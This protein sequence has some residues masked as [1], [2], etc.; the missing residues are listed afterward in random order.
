MTS[1]KRVLLLHAYSAHNAGDGLLV[2]ESIKLVREALGASTEF[3]IAASDPVSFS[4][5]GCL[6][7]NSK[8]SLR[9][10]S[11]A[12]RTTLAGI[13]DFDLVVGVGGGYQ[14]AGKVREALKMGLVH[15]PQ[16]V[17]S[18]RRSAGV[19]Y[20]P[21]SIGPLRLG[22]RRPMTRLLSK[23]EYV[24][25][26]DDRSL[27]EIGR[28]RPLRVPDLALVSGAWVD[29]SADPLNPVPVV[30]IRAI[31]GRV[32]AGVRELCSGLS[33]FDGYVQSATGGNDDRVPMRSVNPRSIVEREDL[34]GGVAPRRLVVA[35]RLH[36]ALMALRAGHAVIH[37]SYERK[38]FGA[39]QDLG[40]DEY[41]HNVF[42]FDLDLVREQMRRLSEDVEVLRRYD[43]TVRIAQ[44]RL[45]RH[46]KDLISTIASATDGRGRV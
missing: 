14:R 28:A 18:S 7:V 4:Y 31:H 25:V 45:S 30:S 6:V 10:Y 24:V 26:R 1:A 8:P 2:D 39:F 41:V 38:G 19:V 5:T 15:G 9:G 17:A 12:Y 36:A 35:V 40:L 37:L 44:D 23:I 42:D 29:R 27:E 32:P 3:T 43:E 21:Q 33:E 20:L 13:G 11:K 16:L 22:T 46:R 34:L